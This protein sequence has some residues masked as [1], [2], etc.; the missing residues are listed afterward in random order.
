[1]VCP[2]KKRAKYWGDENPVQRLISAL[3]S[4]VVHRSSIAP[5]SLWR[6]ISCW[7]VVRRWRR[8]AF[9]TIVCESP[10][11]RKTS[12]A[13]MPLQNSLRMD[14]TVAGSHSGAVG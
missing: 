3:V 13:E 10:T 6:I 9:S 2:R 7:T 4:D 14:P 5:L 8:K 11:I 12:V 1:M